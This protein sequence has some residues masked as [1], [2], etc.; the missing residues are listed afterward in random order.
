[1]QSW[2]FKVLDR[3]L[4]PNTFLIV[5][6][7]TGMRVASPTSSTK[8]IYFCFSPDRASAWARHWEK[9]WVKEAIICSNSSRVML[10]LKSMSSK[11]DSQLRSASLLP[12]SNFRTFSIASSILSRALGASRGS[13]P[14]F[15]R[16]YAEKCSKSK[17]SIWR[18]PILRSECVIN[19]LVFPGKKEQKVTVSLLCPKSTKATILGR[20]WSNSA[21]L[22][23]PYVN[24]I[25]VLSFSSLVHL[26]PAIS[27]ASR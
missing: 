22:K 10:L 7:H 15:L 18:A 5:S 6:R 8:S 14:C 12:E 25:A 11:S 23:K 21:F 26:I 9:R 3:S 2:E 20:C 4:M 19:T 17:R 27:A 13:L 24:A 16:N 1:M